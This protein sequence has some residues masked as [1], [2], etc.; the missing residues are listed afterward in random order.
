M[1]TSE[2]PSAPEP[3]CYINGKRYVLPD[4]RGEATLLQFLREIGLTGTKLGCGEGGCGAC[5][6]ML[7]HWED[8]HVVHR[9]A[10]AC[11]CPLYAVEGMQVVTVEGLG[12]VRDGLHPVQQRLA[13]MHGSQCGFC[14][15]GFVMSMYSLLRSCE[16]PPSEEDIEDALGGNLC[17]CTGYR[18]ILDAFK[19][20][21]K[22]DPAAYTEEA[23]AASKGIANGAATSA[24]TTNGASSG[25]CP[26][27]GLPCDCAAAK[28]TTNGCGAAAP[29]TNGCGAANCCKKATVGGG[30]DVAAA[31]APRPTCEPIFPP[32]LKK[33]PAFHLAVSG[34]HVTWHRPATLEQLL[35]LKAAH[36]TAKIVVGNTEVGIEMK[37]KNANYPVIIAPTHVKEM[38]QITVTE[39]G[40]EIGAAVTLTRM[41]KAFKGLIATRPRHQVSA[42]EAVVNQLRWFAGNQIRNVSALGGNIVTGSPISDLN[43]LWMAARTTFVA[44][45]KDTGERAVPASD[46]FVGYRQVD[47]RPHEILFKVVLPF[48][49]PNEYVKEFKQSPRRE[50][51]IAIVNAGMR[52]KLAPGTSEGMWVVEEAAVAFGGV[53]PR[54]IMAP[55]L[56]A[57]L[58][59]R[60]WDQDA[61]QAA[62]AAVRQDVV[63]VDN[64]PGGKV[65][66]RRALAASFVFKFFVHAALQLEAD[67]EAAYKANLPAEEHSAAKPYERHPAHG[68][69]FY[70]KPEPPPTPETVS[71]VGQ[72]HHHMAAELQVSGEA[73]YTDDI[74][75]TQDALVAALVTSAKPHARITKLDATAALQMPGVVGF[76]SAKDVPGSNAIGPVWYDEEVFAT[77]EV[78]AVGQVIGVVVGTTEAA[79]RAGARAVEVG[80]EDLPAVMSI[81]EAIDVGAFYED[82]TGKLEC[83]DVD[84]AWALCDHVI[85]G[86]YKV[87]GQEHFYLEPNNCLVIPHENDE[88]TLYSS[89]QAPA[90]HQKYVASVLGIPAHKVVS[91]TK[92]LGGGFGGKET[93][94]IFI[95]CAAAVPSYHLKRPVR[96]CLDRDEDMQM[97][98][99]RHAFLATYKVGF[100]AEGRVLA[101][102]LDLYNN[103]GNSHDLSHSI[104]DR[105]LLH[106]DCVYKVPNMR[107]RGHMCR[108]NQASNTAFRGFG[109]PQGLMFAEMWIEQI[110]KTLGKPDVEIRTLNMYD[111]GDVTH[112]GQVLEHCRARACWQ[113]ALSSSSFSERQT[114]VAEFNKA[115]RWRKRGLA[116]TPTKFGISFTTK[117]LNQAGALVHVYLDGT[118]LVTHG[119]VEMG[120]GLH[121]KMAQVAAQ[122]LNVPLSKV[123]ISETSTDKVPNASPTAASA[124][125]DM[126]G[127]AVLDACR[128]LSER[129]APYRAKLPNGTWKEV[130]NAA[131]LDRVDLSAHGFYSTPDITG[132]GGRRPFNYFCFG[133]AVSEVEI[134]VLTGDMQVLR[135]DLV[136]DVGN[137]LNPAIDIGQ[138]EGGFV[139]GMGWLVLEELMWGDK[140]HSWIRPGHLFTKG[141]GTYKIPSVNDIP[142]DFRVQ[143]LA[144]APNVRAI[145][146]SKA[147]GEPPFH[148]GASVFFA[149]KEAVYA[150]RE[151]EGVP[152]YFVLDA[153]ATPERL[154]LL[155]SDQVVQPYVP[156][157]VRPKISC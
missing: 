94:G 21:A 127:G 13:V 81:E 78:T 133:A 70:A 123:F 115:N 156:Y 86:T 19:M 44:L 1:V 57:A 32:E 4:G 22:T 93:R 130:V 129:L 92:R 14:T 98:G 50:D 68:V 152:G 34:R 103:A 28:A 96:L 138:V 53:A 117:F 17:R 30:C 38:N 18:P 31:A 66:Y 135:S 8:G 90:K 63:L 27:S 33:R 65:E 45:G 114:Q 141:P 148:L 9:S 79:A 151:A 89:T 46:F 101:A 154:R 76:Y 75:L 11:L 107:V 77:N 41:M 149:L 48:T 157:D 143:L 84:G 26:S 119:G 99:Q 131:Y 150:A 85:T 60:P 37:F 62:L 122:A 59:G 74:K 146:S 126:Y 61:L 36:P 58:V 155:C 40:V 91:K 108:T 35:E 120:Q 95:H 112:F 49:R 39:T 10:N 111:E 139:Q 24:T 136:M 73:T 83:G 7:S 100:S 105:A 23:I 118:V 124:S 29:T 145:H 80:Y 142:V 3:I 128:Q 72:P 88:F 102:E 97:T 55:A 71:V 132:F 54:A 15:P 12:N 56:A 2:T 67:T 121:T 6:V 134:D 87:G 64:A 25:V 5:T 43:P 125:S 113:T 147:V 82:Y 106:S 20:F 116:A 144:N 69:Q 52:V 47:L 104:M 16:T 110:A 42:L 109:G 51:D 140:Q 137:P 153:P